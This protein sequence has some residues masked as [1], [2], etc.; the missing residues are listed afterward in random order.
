MEVGLAQRDI[1]V[2]VLNE[3][4][5]PDRSFN[6]RPEFNEERLPRNIRFYNFN[7]GV[8]GPL[9]PLVISDSSGLGVDFAL[10]RGASV[11]AGA[12][13]EGRIWIAVRPGHDLAAVSHLDEVKNDELR[14]LREHLRPT[15]P[16]PRHGMHL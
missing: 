9:F 10:I 3:Y 12:C 7:T 4:C 6:P 2:H 8:E 14:Q 15:D 11:G 13:G 16:E 1:P 5:H